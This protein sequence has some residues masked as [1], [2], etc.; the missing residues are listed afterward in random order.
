MNFDEA[1]AEWVRQHYP[2]G[3]LVVGSI[4]F[5]LEVSAYDGEIDKSIELTYRCI[6]YPRRG[7]VDGVWRRSDPVEVEKKVDLPEGTSLTQLM[8]EIVTIVVMNLPTSEPKDAPYA[9]TQ[10]PQDNR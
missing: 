5:E 7:R 9:K 3:Q 1:A 8:R 6:E 4:E 2:A 10:Y